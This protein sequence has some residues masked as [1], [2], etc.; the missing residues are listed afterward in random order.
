[1]IFGKSWDDLY[2]MIGTKIESVWWAWRPVTLRD[3]RVAWLED[4]RKVST[5]GNNLEW[6][7]TYYELEK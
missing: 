6:F 3:G 7:N 1:M 5:Y 2:A 4:V